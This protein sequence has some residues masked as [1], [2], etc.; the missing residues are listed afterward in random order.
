[1]K[2]ITKR[3]DG[4]YMIRKVI[5]GK[6]VTKYTKTLVEARV[7]LQNLKKGKIENKTTKVKDDKYILDNYAKEYLRLYKKPFLKPRT[8]S[9]VCGI[10]NK[11]LKVLGK[12]DIRKLTT[13]Q[14][15]NF[16]NTIERGRSKEKVYVYLNSILQKATDSGLIDK[17]PFRLVVKDK[18]VKCKHEMF[19]FAEQKQI[20]KAIKETDIEHEIY[21]YLMCGC[22]PNELPTKKDFDFEN[23]LIHITGTKNENAMSRY[24]E[25]S[26]Q[27]SIYMQNYFHNQDV[28]PEKYISKRF[29]EICK[30]LDIK[31]PLLY[32]LRHTFASNHFTLGTQAKQVQQWLGHS[33]INITLDQY[34]DIDKT[35][36][37]EKLINLYNNFYYI[38]R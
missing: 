8:F 11:F 34:T 1:M 16:L 35:A 12:Y 20:L 21:I 33:S 17:N 9:D 23:N 31:K 30:E 6:R 18:K 13:E 4:R 28:Q 32:R 37:K 38:K 29:I 36:T 24:V 22:R 3:K 2:G 26:E 15:Q 7:I 5:N 27:F 25:M 19:T 14:I 10:V